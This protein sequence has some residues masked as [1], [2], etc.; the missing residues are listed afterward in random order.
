MPKKI[1]WK[2]GDNKLPENQDITFLNLS[3]VY[4]HIKTL[5]EDKIANYREINNIVQYSRLYV[6]RWSK[7]AFDL[8]QVSRH[9]R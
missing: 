8:S 3:T 6:F 1:D 4:A 2:K 7:K 5:L 9:R